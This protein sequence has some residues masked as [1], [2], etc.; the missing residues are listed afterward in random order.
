MNYI[1]KY[2]KYKNKYLKLK[3][4]IGG[5]NGAVEI[6]Q[7]VSCMDDL[8]KENAI[9][10]SEKKHVYCWSCFASEISSRIG[11]GILL[12]DNGI[13]KCTSIGSKDCVGVFT[14]ENFTKLETNKNDEQKRIKDEII[15]KW[16][17][18]M[19]KLGPTGNSL[20][21]WKK[22]KEAQLKEENEKWTRALETNDLMEIVDIVSKRYVGISCPRCNNYAID[23]KNCNALTCP[24]CKAGYCAVCLKDCG[25]DAHEHISKEHGDIYN[26]DLA[27]FNER[28][29]II[30]GLI[31]T[32]KVLRRNSE[33]EKLIG[34]LF[35][36]LKIRLDDDKITKEFI[37]KRVDA[38]ARIE[39]EGRIE[40]DIQ[41]FA[42]R[43]KQAR[44]A[45]P[46]VKGW[47]G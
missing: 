28:E 33:T 26:R 45:K 5:A 20:D 7:C 47:R 38:N 13:L 9:F 6:Y 44:K 46:Q 29:R 17:E 30:K 8:T 16:T 25:N 15:I 1:Q 37:I 36:K 21:Y 43:R 41:K 32:V 27:I 14:L 19:K 35:N 4:Y 23:Y 18:L 3:N 31:E 12:K 34:P 39:V 11:K 40:A 22:I 24:V 10:C 42:E 2:L